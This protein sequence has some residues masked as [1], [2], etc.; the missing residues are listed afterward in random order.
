MAPTD[1]LE[2]IAE[3][4]LSQVGQPSVERT[5]SPSQ[6]QSSTDRNWEW[7]ARRA[8]DS[9]GGTTSTNSMDWPTLTRW[10]P[11]SDD[12]GTMSTMDTCSDD[13]HLV[14]TNS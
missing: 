9:D 7:L 3:N 11:D 10:A 6:S 4:I 5:P 1:D 12:G 13:L 8:H 2:Q 14:P